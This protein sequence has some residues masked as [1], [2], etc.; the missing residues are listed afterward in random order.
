[1]AGA[2]GVPFVD[3]NRV[4]FLNNGDLFYPRMLGDI[5]RAVRS[6][7]IEAYIYWAGDI[8]LRFAQALSAMA[9][10]GVKVKILLDAIG[11][12]TIGRDILT[13]LE[14]GPC[15]IACLSHGVRCRF[16]HS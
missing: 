1:M 15:E 12:A 3:G 14:A 2:T 13:V 8:G 9:R 16:R 11:L 4:E 6:I 10:Q 5:E 7:T